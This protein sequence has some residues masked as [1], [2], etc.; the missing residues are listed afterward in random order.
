[1]PVHPE[2]ERAWCDLRSRADALGAD[3]ASPPAVTSARPAW[4]DSAAARVAAWLADVAAVDGGRDATL[5]AA[6]SDL[7]AAVAGLT[8]V[9]GD[10]GAPLP[11]TFSRTTYKFFTP[12][13]A[14]PA[15]KLALAARLPLCLPGRARLGVDAG[16]RVGAPAGRRVTS[17]YFDSPRFPD[18]AARA[19]RVEGAAAVRVRRYGDEDE[20]D[21]GEP[22][23][24]V[25]LE[26]KTRATATEAATKKRVRLPTSALLALVAGAPPPPDAPPLVTAL[27]SRL[28]PPHA[29]ITR[30]VASRWAFG[31]VD[32]ATG[33]RVTLDERVAYTSVHPSTLTAGPVAARLCVAVLKVKTARGGEAPAWVAPLLEAAAATPVS[34]SKFVGA[35]AAVWGP[36]DP[37]AAIL[38]S[39]LPAVSAAVAVPTAAAR[40]AAVTLDIA[41]PPPSSPKPPPSPP[42]QATGRHRVRLLGHLLDAARRRRR[43]ARGATL[44][45]LGRVEPNTFF[46]NERTL[47]AWLQVAVLVLLLATSLLDGSLV[48]GGGGAKKKGG[49]GGGAGDG[50]PRRCAS[51]VCRAVTVSGAIIAPAA[52]LLIVYAFFVFR[53]RARALRDPS[54][55]AARFDAV[56]G[57]AA[58]IAL[59]ACGGVATVVAAFASFVWR[60]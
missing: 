34:Y 46:A 49:G 15:L 14:T 2:P 35:V 48:G 44:P 58:L 59:A 9:G 54:R 12:P 7:C 27:A 18:A 55:A 53:A 28:A 31:A 24:S 32:A 22:P 5:V 29:P 37:Q 3:L 11:D 25:F 8:G 19:A 38:A 56:G 43:G 21:G 16:A 20:G 6:A 26:V 39:D 47:I 60:G 13:H 50:S 4:A 1:M 40:A 51:H 17:V 36:S 57:P 45:T 30:T 10:A 42:L 33:L 23:G 41:P 52:C